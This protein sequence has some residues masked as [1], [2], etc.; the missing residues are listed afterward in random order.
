MYRCYGVRR[1]RRSYACQKPLYKIAI[2]Y[3]KKIII[4]IMF[5]FKSIFNLNSSF[6][7]FYC[8]IK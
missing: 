2:L 3:K 1:S 7:L 6:I 4:I 8:S 5:K